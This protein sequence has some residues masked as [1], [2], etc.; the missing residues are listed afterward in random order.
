[1]AFTYSS[2]ESFQLIHPSIHVVA[3]CFAL[4]SEQGLQIL[5]FVL[6][7]KSDN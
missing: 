2:M 6:L 5:I 3:F 7:K 4:L 1:M